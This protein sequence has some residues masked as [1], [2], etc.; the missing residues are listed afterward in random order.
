M[1]S[2]T[3]ATMGAV[4]FFAARSLVAPKFR[5]ALKV[6][7]LVVAIACYHHF[8]FINRLSWQSAYTN[9]DETYTPP[10][11][12]SMTSTDMQTGS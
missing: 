1:F 11:R 10:S 6:S 12:G 2:L 9:A 3:V 7:D 4:F 5:P 8:Y